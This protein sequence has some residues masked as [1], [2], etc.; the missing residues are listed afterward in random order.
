MEVQSNSHGEN[1]NDK[2]CT[3]TQLGFSDVFDSSFMSK[4][5]GSNALSQTKTKQS[6]LAEVETLHNWGD[7]KK[8]NKISNG[9]SVKRIAFR[10]QL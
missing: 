4:D 5:G 10:L 2:E 9:Q 8:C 3:K 1:I 7:F 6:S